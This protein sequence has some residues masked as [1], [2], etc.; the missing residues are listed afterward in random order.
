[1]ADQMA[2][3]LNAL[4]HT[5]SGLTTSV[6]RLHA[7]QGE[8]N[9]QIGAVRQLT[10]GLIADLDE[11]EQTFREWTVKDEWAKQLGMVQNR[12]LEVRQELEQR[13]GQ[14]DDVRRQARGLLQALDFGIKPREIDASSGSLLL[15]ASSYWLS[16]AVVALD[17]WVRREPELARR[18]RDAAY[19]REANRAALFF[20]LVMWRQ[21]RGDVAAAWVRD[22]VSKQDPFRL[23]PD[24]FTILDAVTTG[25][26][27]R[28][29]ERVLR[30]RL[31]E[32]YD[33]LSRD[34][35]IV[36]RQVAR[37]QTYLRSQGHALDGPYQALREH[38]DWDRLQEISALTTPY[39]VVVATLRQLSQGMLRMRDD[40][41]QR[42][43][44]VLASLVAAPEDEERT[45]REDERAL[46]RL[47]QKLQAPV[48]GSGEKVPLQLGPEASV[49]AMDADAETVD[50]L[51]MLSDAAIESDELRVST[52]TQA[53]ATALS[54]PWI[55]RAI[56]DLV[57][58]GRQLSAEPVS[59]TIGEWRTEIAVD[60]TPESVRLAADLHAD[61][62]L[63][64]SLATVRI[65]GRTLALATVGIVI[66]IATLAE[67]VGVWRPGST[68]RPLLDGVVVVSAMALVG[69]SVRSGIQ[70]RYR[71]FVWGTW[72]RPIR[73]TSRSERRPRRGWWFR[74][75]KDRRARKRRRVPG[76]GVD[77]G[78]LRLL[79]FVLSEV[80][81][82][83]APFGV[84]V[85]LV[86]GRPGV[87]DREVVD[88]AVIALA[89]VFVV[90]TLV[91]SAWRDLPERREEIEE[92]IAKLREA[93]RGRVA[94][95]HDEVVLLRATWAGELS[96]AAE[97]RE[98]VSTLPSPAGS[99]APVHDPSASGLVPGQAA[100][101]SA[102]RESRAGTM[103]WVDDDVQVEAPAADPALD[104]PSWSIAPAGSPLDRA[105]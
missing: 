40:P 8:L 1:M 41:R 23:T 97:L 69:W 45:L 65:P 28:E 74:R 75:R 33:H 66:M 36:T 58:E 2:S 43:D 17:A 80:I 84:A 21:G 15:Q 51:S 26:F 19:G 34:E 90:G 13:F 62:R 71:R 76:I 24:F 105:D 14:N 5:I 48:Y 104:L 103:T 27:G 92:S 82:V 67:L 68:T 10:E 79:R 94:A 20:A 29:V 46:K 44:D 54:G 18:A 4:R 83:A 78:F 22:Y 63:R 7:S 72:P 55:V 31:D 32:W 98:L 100:M 42:V 35:S 81:R 102:E 99:I 95:V 6:E 25:V 91:L 64:Q 87:V 12:L 60:A 96:A 53:L 85:I 70:S 37:W 16:S 30:E 101:P 57:S 50:F 38:G 39:G 56:D 59:V 93:L 86:F 77:L 3:E 88:A 52:R 73:P 61:Q 11:F 47:L 89:F 49:A 9:H